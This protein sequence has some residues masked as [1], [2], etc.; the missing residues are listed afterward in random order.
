LLAVPFQNAVRNLLCTVTVDLDS[1]NH[2]T[3]LAFSTWDAILTSVSV[4]LQVEIFGNS[5]GTN[6]KLHHFTYSNACCAVGS[7]EML[8]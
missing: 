4:A 7:W 6:Y 8:H 2:S 3:H 5:S 1:W